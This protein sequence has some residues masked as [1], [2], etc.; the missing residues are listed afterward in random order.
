SSIQ[1]L[2]ISRLFNDSTSC[3]LYSISL[4]DA[5]PILDE[6]ENVQAVDL[7]PRQRVIVTAG[8]FMDQEGE[9]L[10]LRNKLVKV[11]IDSLGFVLIANIDKSKLSSAPPPAE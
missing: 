3:V 7:R 10:E 11:A 8:P 5:L 4:H 9:V 2:G 6:Y 1:L